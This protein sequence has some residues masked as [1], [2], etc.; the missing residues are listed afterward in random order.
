MM[1][2]ECWI[3]QGEHSNEL[4]QSTRR[5][6]A[7]MLRKIDIASAPPPLA[8]QRQASHPLVTGMAN[9]HELRSPSSRR[10]ARKL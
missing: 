1:T 2:P 3:C 10:R 7:W 8:K 9:V 6:R 4:H 5:I